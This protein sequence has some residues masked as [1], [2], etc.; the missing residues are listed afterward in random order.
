M[1]NSANRNSQRSA[2]PA[3]KSTVS[4]GRT[5][6]FR[7]APE[8][9]LAF[10]SEDFAAPNTVYKRYG[11]RLLDILGS[12]AGLILFLPFLP[13]VVLGIKLTSP[14]PVFYRSIRLG[15]GKRPFTFYKFRSMVD[16]AHESRKYMLHLNEAEGPVFKITNDP[17]VTR[18]GAWLRRTSIDEVPQL[19]NVLKGDMSGLKE[20]GIEPTAA[21]AILPTYLDAYRRGGRYGRPRLV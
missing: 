14:G 6:E 21:E 2:L 8:P 11:K 20:L 13:F 16:G 15:Q 19:W 5:Q 4:S 9:I 7:S 17:R 1:Y 18:F 12:L 3:I 10:L